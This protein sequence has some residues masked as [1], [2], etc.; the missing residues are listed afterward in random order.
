MTNMLGKLNS[1]IH[2]ITPHISDATSGVVNKI[3]I[4]SVVTGGTNALVT[5]AIET[6]DPTWLT[7]SNAV[8]IVSIAGS[9]VFMIKLSADFYFAWKKD[10]R[11]QEAHEMAIK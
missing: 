6:Q 10:K 5:T 4:A 1:A 11:E 3:G 7:I 9:I 2:L 8:A